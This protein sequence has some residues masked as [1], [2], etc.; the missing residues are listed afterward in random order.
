MKTQY[1]VDV[2]VTN[3]SWGGGGFHTELHN[4]IKASGDAGMLFVAAAGNGGSDGVGDDNDLFPHYPSSYRLSNLISVAA[5]DR[6]DNRASFSNFGASS[7]HLAAP[8][9]SILSTHLNN[10]Y[11]SLNGTSMAAPHVAGAA[12]LAWSYNPGATAAE[13]KDALLSGVDPITAMSGKSISGGR[14]NA[15]RTLQ[16]TPLPGDANGDG[17]VN[18]TDFNIVAANFG[19]TN[20]TTG[21]GSG[22]LNADGRV[23]L[24]DF[25]LLA[26]NFGKTLQSSPSAGTA[27][28]FSDSPIGDGEPAG[29]SELLDFAAA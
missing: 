4:A 2:R 16:L 1:G 5:T 15:L 8:G 22:D 23:D 29:V 28:S 18:L 13:V 20:I 10:G 27:S 19:R 11:A 21:R 26:S 17:I 14:L 12:S 24:K 25:N 9:V 7:V 3:N 6:N